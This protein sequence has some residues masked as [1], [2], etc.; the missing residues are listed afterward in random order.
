MRTAGI[1]FEHECAFLVGD[2]LQYSEKL[3]A[4]I[5]PVYSRW[6]KIQNRG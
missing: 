6:L 5:V 2:D 3:Y 1:L 4:L